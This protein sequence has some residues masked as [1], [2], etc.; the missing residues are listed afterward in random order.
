MT[1]LKFLFIETVRREINLPDEI[2]MNAE[3]AT[4]IKMSIFDQSYLDFLDEQIR[5]CPRGPE[6]NERLRARRNGLKEFVDKP[7]IDGRIRLVN[8]HFH[9]RVSP[10]E[11]GVIY[12]E[13]YE[14]DTTQ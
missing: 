13:E 2:R 9:I 1:G 10:V 7:I 11:E 12:W 8:K 4:D 14:D 6:W 3:N 5:L